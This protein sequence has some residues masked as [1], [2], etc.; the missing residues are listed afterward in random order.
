MAHKEDTA[1]DTDEA[2]AELR[3]LRE[4]RGLTADRLRA[5]GALMSALGTA[6]AT[7]GVDRLRQALGQLGPAPRFVALQVDLGLDLSADVLGRE[8]VGQDYDF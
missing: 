4:G 3:R 2:L 6:D 5:C 8:P 1:L 7:E